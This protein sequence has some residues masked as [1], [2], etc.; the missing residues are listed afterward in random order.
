[1]TSRSDRRKEHWEPP[2]QPGVVG[3]WAAVRM[4]RRFAGVGVHIPPAR[5]RQLAVGA[6]PASTES[7]DYAFAVA[8]TQIQQQQRLARARR[9]RRRLI[10]ALVV[11]GLMLAALN[12]LICMGYLFISLALRDPA[13]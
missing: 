2:Q 3:R 6:P 1:M 5:L 7:V 12:L 11:A 4:S 9:N 10:N 13:M 8:A